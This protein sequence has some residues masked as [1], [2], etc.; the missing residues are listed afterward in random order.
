MPGNDTGRPHAETESAQAPTVNQEEETG[1]K[2]PQNEIGR[3]EGAA[4][5]GGRLTG[6]R[7]VRKVADD[8]AG[9]Y[10]LSDEDR[11]WVARVVASL[12][13]LTSEEREFL[14]LILQKPPS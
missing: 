6:K 11:E 7:P 2:K 13:P 5:K 10:D 14:A 8:T 12:S 9:K 1:R 4:G 3:T